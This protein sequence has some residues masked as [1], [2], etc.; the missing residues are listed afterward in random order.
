MHKKFS[1]FLFG[2]VGLVIIDQLVKHWSRVAADGTEGRIFL[3]IWPG[4]FELKLIYNYG[5]AF[6]MFQGGGVFLTPVAIIITGVSSVIVWRN[7]EAG[8]GLVTMLALLS[9]GAVGN[10][11][12]RLTMGK[13]TDMFWIR[14]IDFP[15]FNIADV[16]ITIA[17]AMLVLSALKESFSGG[18]HSSTAEESD[19]LSNPEESKVEDSSPTCPASEET[20]KAS[21]E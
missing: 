6:G 14:I 18:K 15:V 17:G 10:L 7:K 4:V 1:A 5:V 9:A 20:S 12:D 16:C 3:P 19:T 13:V 11:I 8:A 2:T 21:Q